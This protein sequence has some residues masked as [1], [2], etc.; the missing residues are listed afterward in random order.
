MQYRA[1]YNIQ[2]AASMTL[3]YKVFTI[4]VLN[5]DSGKNGDFVYSYSEAFSGKSLFITVAPKQLHF[6]KNASCVIYITACYAASV[7]YFSMCL[8]W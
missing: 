1:I 8:S 6:S 7:Y 2:T 4:T 5:T 3:F